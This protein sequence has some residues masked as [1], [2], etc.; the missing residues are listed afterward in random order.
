MTQLRVALAGESGQLT[1]TFDIGPTRYVRTRPWEWLSPIADACRTA[2]ISPVVVP[3]GP[4]DAG[5]V[6]PD[7]WLISDL[8]RPAA[9]EFGILDRL[10]DGVPRASG[11]VMVGGFFSF[12]GFDGLGGWQDAS[13]AGLLP[14]AMDPVSDATDAPDGVTIVPSSD[15]PRALAEILAATPP[16]Y[17]YNR[18]EPRD[19]SFVLARFS[20]WAPAL[21]CSAAGGHGLVAFASDLMPHWAPTL[22]VWPRFPDLVRALCELAASG[23]QPRQ[24]VGERS[25]R[26]R[27]VRS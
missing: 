2:G 23:P 22:S 18:L 3:Y 13:S 25:R 9:A 12:S 14:V 20:D 7:A 8:P 21:V 5:I 17:G 1:E 16:F 6:D 15:C 4:F 19:G 24:R 26:Q 10:R 11:L 27:K